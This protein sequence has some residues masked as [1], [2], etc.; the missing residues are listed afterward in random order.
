MVLNCERY[1]YENSIAICEECR[2]G[3]WR[4]VAN[5]E[6]KLRTTIDQCTNYELDSDKCKICEVDHVLYEEQT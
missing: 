2:A 5:N 6:C 1:N 3:F 4:D